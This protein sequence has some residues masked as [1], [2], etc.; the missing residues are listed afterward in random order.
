M[1]PRWYQQEAA[2]AFWDVIRQGRTATVI[3]LPTGAG[4]SLVIAMLAR[5]AAEWNG[6]TIVLAHRKELL[7]QNAEKL[8]AIAPELSAG[9]YSAGLKSRDTDAD[10]TFAGIQSCYQKAAEF[11]NVKLVLVDECHL[12]PPE[13]RGRYGKFLT[14]LKELNPKL[15]I[16]GLSA[17][18]FRMDEGCI[19]D[20]GHLFESICYHVSTG[21]L[22]EEGFLC[23]LTNQPVKAEADTE[24]ISK[25]GGEFVAHKM[26]ERF[27]ID[28]LVQDACREIVDFTTDRKSVLVFGANVE[29]CHHIAACLPGARVV[30]GD[31]FAMERAETLRAFSNGELKYLIN[32]EVLST[33]YDCP[34]IDAIAIL[35]ATASAGLFAQIVGRGL[36]QAP[37][38]QDCLILDFGG[39]IARHGSLDDD[40]YGKQQ[41]RCGRSGGEGPHK[42]CWK[43]KNEI[44][45][46]CRDC[47][48]CG[49][50]QPMSETPTHGRDADTDSRLLGANQAFWMNVESVFWMAHKS[51]TS[52]I[53]L[54]KVVYTCREDG[55]AGNLSKTQINEYVCIEHEGFAQRKAAAWWRARCSSYVPDLASEAVKLLDQ[56]FC[57]HPNRIKVQKDGRWWRVLD[58]QFVDDKPGVE[59]VC[60]V[61]GNGFDLP[62]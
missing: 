59:D 15:K 5:Q 19:C 26:A 45:A 7:Q 40:D 42:T 55:E 39:N 58:Q 57:R 41:K 61:G 27:D 9:V 43:C 56:G 12:V 33:G 34:R 18:P 13:S 60:T 54:V 46:G 50:M 4:K 16:G 62:F 28:E 14:D 29:H 37:D 3:D 24:G 11:G 1:Q 51:K 38:K 32:C 53:D 49:A 23:K 6:R 22:I 2:D 52:G 21:R 10:V 8:R 31:T 30:T 35:R 20:P 48:E 36:R 47:P 44:A 25:R 17:T